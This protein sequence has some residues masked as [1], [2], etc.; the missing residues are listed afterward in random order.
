MKTATLLATTLLLGTSLSAL[1]DSYLCT[2]GGA[3]RSIAVVYRDAGQPVPCEVHYSKDGQSQILWSASQEAG[4][5]EEKAKAFADQQTSWGW[6]CA[7]AN[8]TDPA[9]PATTDELGTA[10]GAD[11]H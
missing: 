6:Q 1:A 7:M 8:E 10:E 5:C 11:G 2:N 9:T 4:Y 3:E